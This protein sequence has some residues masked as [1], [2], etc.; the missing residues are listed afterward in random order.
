MFFVHSKLFFVTEAGRLKLKEDHPYYYQIQGELR[1]CDKATCYF[2][3]WSPKEFHYQVIERD[4]HFWEVKLFPSILEFYRMNILD[5]RWKEPDISDEMMKKKSNDILRKLQISRTRQA[6]IERATRGQGR[7]PEWRKERKERLT[8]SNFG[9]VIKMRMTTSCQNTV[10][11]I[12]YPDK[13]DNL[14]AIKYGRMNEAEAISELNSI[15]EQE[16]LGEVEECG[17]FVDIWKGF[18]AASPDGLV[19]KDGLVEVKCPIRCSEISVLELAR[20]DSTFCLKE[21][22]EG[23]LEL[24]RNHNYYYQIQGQ[25][26]IAERSVCYFLVWS[27]HGSHMETIEY[28]QEFWEECEEI[29]ENFYRNCLL[30]EIVDPRAPRGLPVRDPEYILQA[31]NLKNMKI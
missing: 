25:L 16:G 28:D 18:L 8:A 29:L 12:L 26:H 23:R 13:L 20:I 5:E 21:V 9:R 27:P 22:E 30:P 31:Q 11:S 15:L 2:V 7:N 4:D 24:K 6:V 1:I 14:Q 19:G 17:I 10:L 3:V